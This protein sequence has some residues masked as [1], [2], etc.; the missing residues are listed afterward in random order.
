VTVSAL[1]W[2]S[3]ARLRMYSFSAGYEL[4]RVVKQK[5]FLYVEVPAPDTSCQHQTN[6]NHY[7]VLGKSMWAELIKRTGFTL[8]ETLDISFEVPAGPDTYWAFFQQ[9]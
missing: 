1:S 2:S 9:K 7:S 5:G 3:A 4:Y 6:Q 8:L